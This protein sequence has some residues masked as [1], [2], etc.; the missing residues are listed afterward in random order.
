MSSDPPVPHRGTP[1]KARK[2][3]RRVL[4]AILASG[5]GVLALLALAWCFRVELF[6][7]FVRER[8]ALEVAR[9]LSAQR[10]TIGA[11]GGDWIGG[12]E[13][14]DVVVEGSTSVLHEARFRSVVVTY[15]LPDLLAGRSR[16]LRSVH[17]D[18]ASATLDVRA[19]ARADSR[20][21]A[22]PAAL[23]PK[24][25]AP[26]AD[27]VPDGL[28]LRI[29]E[30]RVLAPNGERS[31]AC[32]V[33]LGQ[34]APRRELSLAFAGTRLVGHLEGGGTERRLGAR[35]EVADP[36]SLLDLF[37]PALGIRGGMLAADLGVTLHPPRVEARID[38]ADLT[39]QGRVYSRSHLE[40]ALDR[41]RLSVASATL[42]LPGLS[43]RVGSLVLPNP[44]APGVPAFADL[45]G[46]I[47][48]RSDDLS[49]FADVL[50]A[51]LRTLMPIR[52]HLGG[53]FARGVLRIEDAAL[54][55]RGLDLLIDGGSLPFR[56][57]PR[58]A[59]SSEVHF[60][61]VM[62]EFTTML[63]PLDAATFRGRATGV[64]SGTLLDPEARVEFELGRCTASAGGIEA[65]RGRV[66]L[67]AQ[68]LSVEALRVEGVRSPAL[69]D[70][71]PLTLDLAATCAMR[72]L[73]LDPDTLV[74]KL[75]LEGRFPTA[76]LAP[77]FRSANLEP[78]PVG[79]VKLHL[80]AAQDTGGIVLRD[81]G[82]VGADDANVALRVVG[83]GRLPLRWSVDSGLHLLES[84]TTELRI[85]VS[86]PA[87]SAA[88]DGIAC[89]ATLRVGAH[90]VLLVPAKLAAFG[91]KCD[92]TLDLGVGLAAWF[93][94]E[95]KWDEVRCVA[96]CD[97]EA[98]EVQ[99]LPRG[100][101]PSQ[102]LRGLVAGH[103][104]LAREQGRFAPEGWLT[105]AEG[106]VAGGAG[107][108]VSGLRARI[109]VPRRAAPEAPL[110]LSL[111]LAGRL[112]AGSGLVGEVHGASRF[113]VSGS[114][115]RLEPA[116]LHLGPST[117]VVEASS[118]L[119]LS[120]VLGGGP[121]LRD[122]SLRGSVRVRELAIEPLVALLQPGFAR[123]GNQVRGTGGAEADFAGTLGSALEPAS[124]Q[125][126]RVW[127]RDAEVKA[128]TLPRFENLRAEIVGDPH[129]L[130][131]QAL[132]GT[133][134]A[135][136]FLAR[137]ELRVSGPT[138]W[139]DFESAT[140]DAK[141]TGTDVLLYRGDGAKVRA[142]V[143]VRA[144]GTLK[145]VALSG[146]LALGRG[147]KFVR[148]I[149]LLPDLQAR[150]GETANEGLRLAELPAQLGDRLRLDLGL[151]TT[152]AF[153]VRTNVFD[154]EIDVAAR[155]RGKGT[156][157]RIEGTM[158][159]RSGLL[160]F[161]GANLRIVSGLLSFTRGDPRFPDLLVT[162]EGKRMGIAITM[163]LSGRYDRPQMQ[164]SSVPPLP[165]QDL[166]VLLTTGQLP[167][168]LAERGAEQQA[169]FVGGYLAKEVVEAYFGS[170][171]TE[172]GESLLDRL[173]IETGREVSKNGIESLLVEF[174]ITNGL[175]VQGE[176]DAFED[177]N[178]GL[179]LRF[180]FR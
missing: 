21:D 54:H 13:A 80:E 51:S 15:A 145:D 170:E 82:I 166:I 168:Q 1:A 89:D 32:E 134:G 178:L 25:W 175:S 122:P 36:G 59:A 111:D 172:R 115:T 39:H 137:G 72:G 56:A 126:V 31:G 12:L 11:L 24:T 27:L 136:R 45:S 140:L 150:G 109:E 64:L 154:G 2:R 151:T 76:V 61:V 161:P 113:V 79:E 49:P 167:S 114:G 29:D 112:D 156:A 58:D 124:L 173:T 138:L 4:R 110:V 165:P 157:P 22:E 95:P 62:T 102:D 67:A 34:V 132:E 35:L 162:A 60:R 128:G 120:E 130:T 7:S 176:R 107:S 131:L 43:V 33:H 117:I 142:D 14:H 169:R 47:A 152:E 17:M 144:S 171:S 26:F 92:A 158:V 18:L 69:R 149:S 139:R 55:A 10:V 74:V 84:G 40:A 73:V 99:R 86:R 75:G 5:F 81:L 123:S 98:L 119:T 68:T 101:L 129:S 96:T 85:E 94:P 164:L 179:V 50:P 180:R 177:Y 48:L 77:Y 8:L 159:M 37:A 63:G 30:L 65:A 104:R 143:D 3:R 46:Q 20:P 9:A 44:L 90:E 23:D 141:L 6:G 57:D 106:G 135:G 93:G 16:G 70:A 53:H 116:T 105:L 42:D 147:S 103:L 121:P 100:W 146:D 91:A 160:R 108:L 148:R 155:L 71:E 38:L 83:A 174:E 133:L 66:V 88:V 52:G 28:Q 97:F 153:L 78:A 163:T 118:D 127:L 19:R 125:R 41:E 87:A